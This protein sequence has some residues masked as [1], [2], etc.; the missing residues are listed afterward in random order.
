MALL[1]EPEAPPGKCAGWHE[2]LEIS[3]A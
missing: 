1:S 3:R 2:A